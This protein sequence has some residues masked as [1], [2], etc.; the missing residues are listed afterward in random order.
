M[1]GPSTRVLGVRVL[2]SYHPSEKQKVVGVMY[3]EEEWEV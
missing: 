3:R 2:A 1:I